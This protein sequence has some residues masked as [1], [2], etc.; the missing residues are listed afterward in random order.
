M[1]R[2]FISSLC[3]RPA[4]SSAFKGGLPTYFWPAAMIGALLVVGLLA[5]RLVGWYWLFWGSSRF[6]QLF[7]EEVGLSDSTASVLGTVVAFFYAIAFAHLLGTSSWKV[8]NGKLGSQQTF[9]FLLGYL[10]VFALPSLITG[11]AFSAKKPTQC[12]NQAT[13]SAIRWY[14]MRAGAQVVMF[15]SPGFDEFGIEKKP[16]TH[17]VC[18]TYFRQQ[19]GVRPHKITTDARTIEFFDP[20]TQAPRVW[21]S[22][23]G[24]T[25]SLFDA[26]GFDP[27]TSQTVVPVT[28][29]IVKQLRA[30]AKQ[31][32]SAVRQSSAP[33]NHE[34][35]PTQI[36]APLRAVETPTINARQI[37]AT[38]PATTR[39]PDKRFY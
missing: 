15:D 24:E 4:S 17:E 19:E 14:V 2:P 22:K 30:A 32:D 13:G 26:S 10:V 21:Y 31:T 23:N 39:L 12:F 3:E 1:S 29:E 33:P 34:S 9:K 16:V 5:P 8:L 38:T 36:S 27:V 35:G 18:E 20:I 6:K 25:I 28:P 11:V 7:Y 37:T